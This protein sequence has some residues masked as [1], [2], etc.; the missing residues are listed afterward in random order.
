MPIII[1]MKN[2]AFGLG[3]GRNDVTE[4]V[5]KVNTLLF[6]YAKIEPDEVLDLMRDDP[7][8]LYIEKM[9]SKTVA[10]AAWSSGADFLGGIT[11]LQ[12]GI[13]SLFLGGSPSQIPQSVQSGQNVGVALGGVAN[14]KQMARD[15][16]A[17][18]Q[19][20]KQML[21]EQKN[22]PVGVTGNLSNF[23]NENMKIIIIVVIV[24][25]SVI[26]WKSRK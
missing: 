12:V 11:G 17:R 2:K 4:K 1:N 10:G 9:N 8:L 25:L 26:L 22:A 15:F 13:G 3:K 18:Y 24:I 16:V 21:A 7:F 5:D 20:T 19:K 23:V 14:E 6:H